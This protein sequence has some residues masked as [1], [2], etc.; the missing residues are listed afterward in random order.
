MG[1]HVFLT[2]ALVGCEWSASSP[3]RFTLEKEPTGIHWIAGWVDPRDGLEDM[4]KRKFFALSGLELRSLGRP[5]RCQS[6]YRLSYPGT[7]SDYMA[8]NVDSD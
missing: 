5:A 3:G 8:S 4:E 7:Y 6:L 2:S 1:I